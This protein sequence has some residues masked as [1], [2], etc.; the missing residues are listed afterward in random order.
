MI[1]CSALIIINV[2]YPAGVLIVVISKITCLY[3]SICS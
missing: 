1:D 2:A 3:G